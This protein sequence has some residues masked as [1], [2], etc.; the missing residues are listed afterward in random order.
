MMAEIKDIVV[1]TMISG[2]PHLD[3]VFKSV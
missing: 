3:S 1:K 2:Q